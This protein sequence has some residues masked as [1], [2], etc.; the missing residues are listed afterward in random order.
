[1]YMVFIHDVS[2]P[3]SLHPPLPPNLNIRYAWVITIDTR[4]VPLLEFLDP[5]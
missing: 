2:H 1:M 5:T 4:N 3:P